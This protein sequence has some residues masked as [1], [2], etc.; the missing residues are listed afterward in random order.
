MQRA[1][2]AEAEAARDAR[3]KVI[4][5]EGEKKSANALKEASD[6]I[7]SSPSALQVWVY[8]QFVASDGILMILIQHSLA[9]LSANAEHH[10]SREELNYCLPAAHGTADTIPGQVCAHD[11]VAPQTADVL[12]PAQRSDIAL[13]SAADNS[14]SRLRGKMLSLPDI[15]TFVCYIPNICI[16]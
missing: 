9:A 8:P 13:I 4:A 7:S 10:L 5:A 12:R 14:L 6:V 3:A 15:Y 2:A 11:A 1:M 16:V